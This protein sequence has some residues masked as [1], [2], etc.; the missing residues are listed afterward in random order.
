MDGAARAAADVNISRYTIFY[1][2]ATQVAMR[3]AT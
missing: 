3:K 1:F 2:V